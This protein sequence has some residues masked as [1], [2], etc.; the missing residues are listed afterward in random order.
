MKLAEFAHWVISESAFQGNDL[1]GAMVQDKAVE[2]GICVEITYDPT[3]HGES[4]WDAEPGDPWYVFSPALRAALR[5]EK[6][7][8]EQGK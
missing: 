3:K 6:R 7:A 1:D 8:K 4:Q 2:C 5:R